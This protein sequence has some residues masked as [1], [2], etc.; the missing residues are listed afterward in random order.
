MAAIEG[1][2]VYEGM[3]G[4]TKQYKLNLRFDEAQGP[5]LMVCQTGKNKKEIDPVLDNFYKGAGNWEKPMKS[6][7]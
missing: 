1:Y 6:E 3:F 5:L 2:K 7:R 4:G